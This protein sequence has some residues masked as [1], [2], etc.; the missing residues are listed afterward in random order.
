MAELHA[1][2]ANF[3]PEGKRGDW[4]VFAGPEGWGRR[5]LPRA[6]ALARGLGEEGESLLTCARRSARELDAVDLSGLSVTVVHADYR[7]A[8]ILFDGD[9]VAAVFD[10]D[11]AFKAPRLL[12]MG[13][14]LVGFRRGEGSL[15]LD[16]G[17]AVSTLQAAPLS[18]AEWEVLPAILRWRWVRDPIT[19]FNQMWLDVWDTTLA[20]FDG[21]RRRS[22]GWPGGVLKATKKPPQGD[23]FT[24]GRY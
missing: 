2:G 21:E 9:R 18:D 22:S 17:N 11:V 3:Q 20:L 1:A 15:R 10:F 13:R 6:E 12:D 24:N 7:M 16:I 4:P 14:L 23:F 8:N 5:W 19:E